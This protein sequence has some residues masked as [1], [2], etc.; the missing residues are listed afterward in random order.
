LAVALKEDALREQVADEV[1]CETRLLD[2]RLGCRAGWVR[3]SEC[4][5]GV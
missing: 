5:R 4:Q 3:L 2:D 1:A